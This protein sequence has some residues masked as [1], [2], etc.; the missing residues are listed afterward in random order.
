MRKA[1]ENLSFSSGHPE[2][3]NFSVTI[4]AGITRYQSNHRSLDELLKDADDFLYEAKG[5]GRNR[6]I[7]RT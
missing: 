6:S 7:F 4:S 5:S 3:A 2:K 1:I